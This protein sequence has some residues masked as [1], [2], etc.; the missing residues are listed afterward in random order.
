MSI[1]FF[2]ASA[3]VKYFHR[4]PGTAWVRQVV[5]AREP[6]NEIYIAD[7]SLAEVPAALAILARAKQISIRMRDSLYAAFL[8]NIGSKFQLLRVTT[9]LAYA[10]GELTQPHPLK[11][12][13][14]VQLALALDFNATLAQQ[15]LSAIFV[16]GDDRLVQA[17]KAEGMATGN[18]FLHVDLDTQ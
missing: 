5:D 15:G 3:V 13:D 10:A 2:D 18:P 16:S 12:Y 17:A 9:S 14:A 4:E 1:Y 8:D 7:I 11:G 6:H